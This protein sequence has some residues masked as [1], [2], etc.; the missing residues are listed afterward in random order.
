MDIQLYSSAHNFCQPDCF[1][2]VFLL[3][4]QEDLA[5]SF[6]R[7]HSDTWS[8]SCHLE[9][10]LL[11]IYLG[12]SSLA[13][14]EFIYMTYFQSHQMLVSWIP[15]AAKNGPPLTS[16]PLSNPALD[17]STALLHAPLLKI[18]GRHSLRQ[19]E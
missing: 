2:Q 18:Q 14:P 3:L 7:G 16:R 10:G 6:H 5:I 13:D 1:M 15:I 17:C 9:T 8:V 11:Q 12:R 4:H 19:S